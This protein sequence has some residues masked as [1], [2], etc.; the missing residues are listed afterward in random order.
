M[1][2][3]PSG[4]SPTLPLPR[5]RSC[6]SCRRAAGSRRL[7]ATCLTQWPS[8][9]PSS[10]RRTRDLMRDLC[11][12][13]APTARGGMLRSPSWSR[14]S[15]AWRRA[16]RR[17]GKPL[18]AAGRQAFRRRRRSAAHVLR[19]TRC[20]TAWPSCSRTFGSWSASLRGAW[21]WRHCCQTRWRRRAAWRHVMAP[22]QPHQTSR[23]HLGSGLGRPP[24][25]TPWQG[26]PM[27]AAEVAA[28]AAGAEEEVGGARWRRCC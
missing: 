7:G 2:P 25:A 16:S 4:K 27:L 15:A 8:N 23:T 28:A 12:H 3:D 18:S 10:R 9:K 5:R 14:R 21:R 1:S 13:S 24:Q 22:S 26:Q 11:R 19:P 6:R 17:E 20:R